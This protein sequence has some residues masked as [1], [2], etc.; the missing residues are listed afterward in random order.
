VVIFWDLA[1]YTRSVGWG[2][3]G[4]W[5]VIIFWD[6][7]GYTRSV[8]WGRPGGWSTIN[9]FGSGRLQQISRLGAPRRLEYD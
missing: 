7:A 2:R 6:L 8:G 3:P 9:F 4:G 5:N 1:G